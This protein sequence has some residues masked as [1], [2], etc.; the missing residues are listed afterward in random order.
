MKYKTHKQI[1][2]DYIQRGVFSREEIEK[3]N[4]QF[5]QVRFVLMESQAQAK[6]FLRYKMG[7][8]K[9]NLWRLFDG[10][11]FGIYLSAGINKD[12]WIEKAKELGWRDDLKDKQ[13]REIMK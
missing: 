9:Y 8:I 7:F 1:D 6:T 4:N 2:E 13:I 10:F 3:M 12:G 5:E 11:P